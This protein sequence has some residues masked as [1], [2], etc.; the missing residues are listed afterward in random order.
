M[1][2]LALGNYHI[3]Q[4]K[5]YAKDQIIN[6][7]KDESNETSKQLVE[8]IKISDINHL[9][10]NRTY[11]KFFGQM[12]FARS[13][14]NFISYFKDILSEIVMINPNI[15]KSKEKERLD[16]ILNFES[17][18]DLRK[19]ISEKK[20]DELFYKGISD[21]EIFFTDRL[22]I[23]LFKNDEDKNGIN[24]M[25]KQRNLIVHN[26]G[27]I[28]KEFVTEFPEKKHSVG[29]YLFYTYEGISLLNVQLQNFLVDLDEEL[30]KKFRLELFKC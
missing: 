7:Y 18:S 19:A 16:F 26:R 30:S 9:F 20:I 6:L 22:G 2:F 15:L 4:N 28:S 27:K 10:D 17:L 11:E 21:I 13:I 12:S 24:Y 29:H 3:N 1:I 14:D 5:Q 23:D 8:F 25:I